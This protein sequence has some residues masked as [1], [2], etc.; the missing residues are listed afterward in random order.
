MRQHQGPLPFAEVTQR[1][2]AV[3][4]WGTREIENI[5]PDLEGRTKKEAEAQHR[6]QIHGS[7]GTD[8]RAHSQRQ[9]SC[10]PAG[11]LHDQVQVVICSEIGT[12]LALPAQFQS[13]AVDCLPSHELELG[14]DPSAETPPEPAF[15][16]PQRPKRKDG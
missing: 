5:V 2:L 10:V 8:E 12:T 9:H 15:V 11:L 4:S 16:I 13:L 7:F 14:P 1:F 3:Y 6:F